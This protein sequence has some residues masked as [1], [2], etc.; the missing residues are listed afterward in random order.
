M[1]TRAVLAALTAALALV[2]P[3][4]EHLGALRAQDDG[5][6]RALTSNDGAHRLRYRTNPARLELGVD[7]EVEVELLATPGGPPPE[8]HALTIDGDMPEHGHGLLREPRT[9][10]LAPGRFRARGLR[11]FMPGHWELYFDVTAGAVTERAQ[12]EVWID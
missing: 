8:G 5:G 12:V 6:W 7:F 2:G 9:E 10:R 1:R 4:A 3:R 11:L